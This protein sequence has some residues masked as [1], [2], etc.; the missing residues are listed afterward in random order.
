MIPLSKKEELLFFG[1]LYELVLQR[2]LTSIVDRKK[3][4]GKIFLD[5]L[6]SKF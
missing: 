5:G 6:K 4:L 1:G 2:G 3:F